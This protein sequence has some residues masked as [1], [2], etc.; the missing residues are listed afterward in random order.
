MA[1]VGVGVSTSFTSCSD[2]DYSIS[3]T[4]VVKS[5]TTGNATVTAIS[6]VTTGNVQ[7]LSGLASSSYQVGTV[8]G[9]SADLEATGNKQT[10]SIDADG[11]VSTTI[12]GLVDGATYYYTTYVTLQGKVTIYSED[13]KSF[14]ATDAD[15]ATA[16][17]T[18][19]SSCKAKLNG[20]LTGAD[21]DFAATTVGFLYSTD[22]NVAEGID[23][24][25]EAAATFEAEIAGLLPGTKYYYAAYSKVGDNYMLGNVQSFT[26][27]EQQM[28]YVD[29][30]L[31]TMWAK[32]N[33]GAENENELGALAGYGDQTFFNR[34][35]S[36]DGYPSTDIVGSSADMLADMNIDGDSP[37][38]SKM[39]TVDQV[40]ELIAKTTQTRETVN[41]VE[42]VRFTAVNGNSIFLPMTGYRDGGEVV[43]NGNAYY[44]TGNVS[45]INNDYAK[46]LSITAEGVASGLTKRAYGIA[47][48]PVRDY[49]TIKPVPGKCVVGDLENNGRIRIEIYNEYGSTK[50]NSAVDPNSVKFKHNMVV[51]FNISGID[52]NMKE[53]AASYHV[54]GLEYSDPSWGPSYWSSL[55]MGKYEAAVTGDG[56]YS[57][58]CETENANGA[59]VFCIDIK[60]LAAD[61]IDPSL[62]KADVVEIKL[63][64]DTEQSVNTAP[65]SFQ[66][67]DGNGVDGR[68][69]IYNEYGNGGSVAPQCYNAMKFNG[70]CC[71]DFTI[72]GIDGNLKDGAAGNYK[73]ELSY[74]AASWDPSY[75]GG[76]D[77]G[78]ANVKGDGSYR[79]YTY[80]KGDCVGAVV[81][82]IELYGLWQDLVDTD[83]VK[84]QV[85]SITVPNKL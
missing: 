27:A 56:T 80:L 13:V 73:T 31:S 57:V 39:P 40:K 5:I 61:A 32:C 72:S 68:I 45:E 30:G 35:T 43:E 23:L 64:A 51:T 71:V 19:L 63:D 77:F 47:V 59:V 76:N 66:N 22:A 44:W 6:A 70:M 2:D 81:W 42:G 3:E 74:A 62:I 18:Q 21:E 1:A 67:K 10:G 12:N 54:A 60:D 79:V 7:D 29:L 84:V 75:W 20:Q 26:T 9:T 49:A 78:A 82:T 8:Y 53:G 28:E 4:Q 52:G 14:V 15:V 36:V 48:R 41:G 83:K 46:T 33:V 34:V 58:W 38:K 25:V 69:E 11:N 55:D 17:A 65:V 24:P 16:A 50:G 37:M 85:N